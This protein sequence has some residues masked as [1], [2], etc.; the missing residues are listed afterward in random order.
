MGG[1]GAGGELGWAG[2]VEARLGRPELVRVVAF[3]SLALSF[4]NFW[5]FLLSVSYVGLLCQS[6]MS[7]YRGYWIDAS[8]DQ[9]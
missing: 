7:L 1:G 4:V 6:P 9:L 5:L 8:G 2:L 3:R